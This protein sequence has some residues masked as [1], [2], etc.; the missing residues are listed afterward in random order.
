MIKLKN[1]DH[2]RSNAEHPTRVMAFPPFDVEGW[3]LDIGCSL[4]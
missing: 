4:S 3:M 1:I 2:P